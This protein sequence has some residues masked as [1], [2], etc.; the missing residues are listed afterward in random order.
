M[1][2]KDYCKENVDRKFCDITSIKEADIKIETNPIQ[3]I[4]DNW[5]ILLGIIAIVIGFLL[6]KFN[7]AVFGICIGF[8]L[9]FAVLFIIGNK[10]SVICNKDNIEIK[11]YFQKTK[12]EYKDVKN[13]YIE[14]TARGIFARTYVLVIRCED[15][16]ALLRE[17]EFPL[18]CCNPDEVIKF[19]DNF[20]FAGECDEEALKLDKKRS[21]RRIVN[22]MFKLMCAIIIAWFCIVKGII[23]LPH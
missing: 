7:L 19:V 6:V 8:A 15:R 4:K 14:R 10:Y 1:N 18:L 22:N 17:F 20:K 12:V 2:Y 16:L 13:V 5:I 21:L 11:Q 3:T 9:L 23:K